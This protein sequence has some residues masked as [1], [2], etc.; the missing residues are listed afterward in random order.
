MINNAKNDIVGATN[1]PN[2]IN[3]GDE[4]IDDLERERRSLQ[5]Q[6]E[7][8]Q[9]AIRKAWGTNVWRSSY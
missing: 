9:N 2:T 5:R 3:G 8:H 1:E 7:E 6:Q 4:I